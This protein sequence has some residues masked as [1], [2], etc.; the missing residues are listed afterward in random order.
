MNTAVARDVGYVAVMADIA[1]GIAPGSN[2]I[3]L[4]VEAGLRAE[5]GI[6]VKLL[7][8]VVGIEQEREVGVPYV[9]AGCVL[10]FERKAG[11]V[12]KAGANRPAGLLFE[13]G[14]AGRRDDLGVDGGASVCEVAGRVAGRGGPQRD[15]GAH[16]ERRAT[17]QRRGGVFGGYNIGLH[18]VLGGVG[19]IA[20]RHDAFVEGALGAVAI[21]TADTENDGALFAHR[22]VARLAGARAA[23]V[24]R[25]RAGRSIGAA[26]RPLV[27]TS[28]DDR[29]QEAG[30]D[31]GVASVVASARAREQAVLEIGHDPR[32]AARARAPSSAVAKV[33]G[34]H[35]AVAD[36]EIVGLGVAVVEAA[37][38]VVVGP[39]EDGVHAL[40]RVALGRAAHGVVA[41]AGAGRDEDAVRLLAVQ[42]DR[43]ARGAGQVVV[44]IGFRALEAAGRRLGEVIT[45][46]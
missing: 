46:A 1:G 27:G 11:A 23:V 18:R 16:G 39:V 36:I 2:R 21:V 10:G 8:A 29:R 34:L 19:R 17:G 4:A 15:G 33:D 38:A 42:R 9:A 37:G 26:D 28:L 30:G 43:R 24:R 45:A 12:A 25:Q 32:A 31:G 44:T 22:V 3:A 40:G 41:V 35:V 6:L 14:A 7:G 5:R 13:G 20:S